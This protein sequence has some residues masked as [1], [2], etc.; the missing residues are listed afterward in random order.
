MILHVAIGLFVG[1]S[2]SFRRSIVS[3][4]VVVVWWSPVALEAPSKSIGDAGV[5]LS[6]CGLG[7]S[8]SVSSERNGSKSSSGSFSR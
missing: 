1:R 7:G 4:V 8:H 3:I 2:S 5:D 6:F